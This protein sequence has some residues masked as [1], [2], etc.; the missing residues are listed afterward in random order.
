MVQDVEDWSVMRRLV[1]INR[2]MN[3]TWHPGAASDGVALA[4]VMEN[5]CQIWFTVQVR[6]RIFL[7]ASTHGGHR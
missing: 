3:D 2:N 6:L 7:R 4:S 5:R 1:E